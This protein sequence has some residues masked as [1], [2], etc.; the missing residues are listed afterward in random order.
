[1]V[2]ERRWRGKRGWRKFLGGEGEPQALLTLTSRLTSGAPIH[3]TGQSDAV[4]ATFNRRFTRD[5]LVGKAK[6]VLFDG[7]RADTL[8]A[9]IRPG[10]AADRIGFRNSAG[11]LDCKA[12]IADNQLIFGGTGAGQENCYIFDFDFDEQHKKTFNL[13]NGQYL[14]QLP[15]LLLDSGANYPIIDVDNENNA[16]M[17]LVNTTDSATGFAP[18]SADEN[19]S[20][21]DVDS[22][23]TDAVGES[24]WNRIYR[25]IE[26]VISM[27]YDM[28][29]TP[30]SIDADSITPSVDGGFFNPYTDGDP[31][32]PLRLISRFGGGRCPITPY[33]LQQEEKILLATFNRH[34]GSDELTTG[35]SLL[36]A[37][38]D[39]ESVMNPVDAIGHDTYSVNVSGDDSIRLVVEST[40]LYAT[41]GNDLGYIFDVDFNSQ[42]LRELSVGPMAED[43]P[44]AISMPANLGIVGED[45]VVSFYKSD[46]DPEVISASIAKNQA[47]S[48]MSWDET[49]EQLSYISLLQGWQISDVVSL[50]QQL[51]EFEFGIGGMSILVEENR[52]WQLA[53]TFNLLTDSVVDFQ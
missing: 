20:D 25:I 47:G 37:T 51:I 4:F 10:S 39:G 32:T 50:L 31:F 49:T 1:M 44:L 46:D 48:L 21:I 5:E 6:L 16:M 35:L 29:N 8:V 24:N 30:L 13:N 17:I 40:R 26:S 23:F 53:G 43:I 52:D 36:V 28:V 3:F 7:N 41:N 42:H 38:A 14:L 45:L 27:E 2:P 12:I 15:N 34:P 11:S 22:W 9:Y 18:I 19:L 33:D